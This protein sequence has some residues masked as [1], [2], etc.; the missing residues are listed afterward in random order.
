MK[1]YSD[2]TLKELAAVIRAIGEKH[3]IAEVRQIAAAVEARDR[4]R[5]PKP[6]KRGLAQQIVD[7]ARSNIGL[8]N[9]EIGLAFGVGAGVVSDALH[10]RLK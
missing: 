1:R 8:S 6:T 5:P 7:F 3:G 10:G 9:H 4:R 2:M